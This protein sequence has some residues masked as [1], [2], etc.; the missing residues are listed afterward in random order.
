MGTIVWLVAAVLF[1]VFLVAGIGCS[2]SGVST[3]GR[4][5]VV[6]TGCTWKATTRRPRCGSTCRG[7]NNCWA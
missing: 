4:P 3:E 6:R 2:R 5:P 7:S 1:V